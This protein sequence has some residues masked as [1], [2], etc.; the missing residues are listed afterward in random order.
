M[1]LAA[2]PSPKDKLVTQLTTTG[3]LALLKPDIFVKGRP[4]LGG[5]VG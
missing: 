1:V 3:R 4:L 5:L 2:E